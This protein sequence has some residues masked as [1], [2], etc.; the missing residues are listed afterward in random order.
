MRLPHGSR[1]RE[2]HSWALLV[3]GVCGLAGAV[4][5]FY[6]P[7]PR[8][9]YPVCP[10]RQITGLLCPG[11]GGTHALAALIHGELRA[12]LG[13]N[14]LVTVAVPLALLYGVVAYARELW[15]STPLVLTRSAYILMWLVTL[16]FAIARNY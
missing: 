4:L 9:L 3:T 14:P 13:F 15:G 1:A 16:G 10:F 8:T 5:F 11:C 6:P 2:A 7:G 12:A